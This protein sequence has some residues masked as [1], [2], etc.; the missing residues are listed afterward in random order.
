MRKL[1]RALALAALALAA[2]LLAACGGDDDGASTTAGERKLDQVDVQL[3]YQVRGNHAMFFVA[4]E[5]GFFEEEGI[6]VNDIRIGTGSPDAMRIV[7]GGQAD[8][9]F[10]DLPTLVTARTQGAD[11]VA[12]AAVNQ[13]TP[14]GFCAKRERHDLRSPRD[15]V[16]LT[17][18]A[19]TAG[20]TYIF[21]RA[22]IAANGIE[23]SQIKEATVTPPF[24]S[25][26]LQ[27]RVDFVVCYIDAEVPELEARA[28]GPGSLSILHGS[29]WGYD[30]YGS[31][32]FTSGKLIRENP[33]LVQRFVNAY[34]KAF[35]YVIEN[36]REVAELL[37][38]TSPEL[39][40]KAHVFEAQLQADIDATFTSPTTDAGG[41][42][43]MDPRVWR[44][45]IDVLADQRVIERVPAVEEV[46]DGT[47]VEKANASAGN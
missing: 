25:F 16:G 17:F 26:L 6:Q 14:L 10:G 35:E 8:F 47:F 12:L 30:A 5:K 2:A 21:Y 28:G 15:L 13:R 41:L 23:R 44:S 20:S 29:D 1:Y 18:G 3:D 4:K 39:K 36:P 40:G 11:V 33:D 9:G 27:D 7:A 19:H 43:A 46:Y 42:G 22:V 37:E 24:E 31:G 34:M 32:L 45:T 38:T